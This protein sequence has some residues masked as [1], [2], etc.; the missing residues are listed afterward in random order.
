MSPR[1]GVRIFQLSE[2]RKR[3]MRAAPHDR[4][5]VAL[6]ADERKLHFGF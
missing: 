3:D 2:K 1:L 6:D 5:A 4:T